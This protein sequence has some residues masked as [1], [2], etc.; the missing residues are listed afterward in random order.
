M[1]CFVLYLGSFEFQ[2]L[3][4]C[5]KSSYSRNGPDDLSTDGQKDNNWS[6]L[7]KIQQLLFL[8]LDSFIIL[9]P[10]L[11]FLGWSPKIPIYHLDRDSYY[12]HRLDECISENLLF[13]HYEM[14]LPPLEVISEY[15]VSIYLA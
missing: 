3:L 2:Y 9:S 7:K 6:E 11:A 15:K 14:E 13:P 4:N 1:Y 10:E 12:Y 5:L 8:V